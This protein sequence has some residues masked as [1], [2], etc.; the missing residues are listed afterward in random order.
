MVTANCSSSSAS[1]LLPSLPRSRGLRDPLISN[2]YN[3]FIFEIFTPKIRSRVSSLNITN[4]LEDENRRDT[5][6]QVVSLLMAYPH[7][8]ICRSMRVLESKDMIKIQ[9][10]SMQG[11]TVAEFIKHRSNLVRKEWANRFIARQILDAVNHLHSLGLVTPRVDCNSF[12]FR[13]NCKAC[14]TPFQR[15]EIALVKTH[16]CRPASKRSDYIKDLRWCGY[17]LHKLLC[18]Q[19]Y[20]I[21]DTA[22]TSLRCSDLALDLCKRLIENDH[23]CAIT[24]CDEA[25]DHA[26]F[27]GDTCEENHVDLDPRVI[28]KLFSF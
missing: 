2:D 17:I 5:M 3:R 10:E 25:L 6:T 4:G 26:W 13:Y 8:H 27:S 1:C 18:V 24:T 22:K 12:M 9:V 16:H 23:A 21:D 15:F 19:E 7:R 28:R 14:L 20:G 11:G